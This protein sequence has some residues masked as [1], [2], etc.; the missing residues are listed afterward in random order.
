M[1]GQAIKKIVF[2]NICILSKFSNVTTTSKINQ[3]IE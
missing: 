1:Y 2:I 3:V